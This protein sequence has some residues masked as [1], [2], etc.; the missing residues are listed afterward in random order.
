M[1]KYFYSISSNWINL[2]VAIAIAFIVSPI[3][4]NSL[5]KDVYGI[6]I[7][8]VSMTSY[9]TLL[10][11][12]VNSAIVKY[13]S[14]FIARNDHKNVNRIFSTSL[15]LFFL[16]AMIT[17]VISIF[18]ALNFHSF[19]E[20][21]IFSK[22]YVA[23]T[24]FIVGIDLTINLLFSVYLGTLKAFNK[25]VALNIINI[26][27]AITKN[28]IFVYLLLYQS[29]S[30]LTLSLVQLIFTLI[31]TFIHYFLIKSLPFRVRFSFNHIS[32]SSLKILYQY[33]IYSFLIAVSHKMIFYTDTIIIGAIIGVEEIAY[34]AIPLTLVQYIEQFVWAIIAVLIPIIS[35]KS[36]FDDL[37]STK[38]IYK[39]GTKYIFLLFSPVLVVLFSVGDQFIGMWMG[40]DFRIPS[41][42]ILVIFLCGYT[43]LLGQLVAHGILKGIGKHKWLAI[44]LLFE[45]TLNLCISLLLAPV[46]GIYGV[47][48]GTAIPMVVM[49]LLIIPYIT[50]YQLKINVYKYMLNSFAMPLLILIL[51]TSL[52]IMLNVELESYWQLILYSSIVVLIY[53]P[54]FYFSLENSEKLKADSY[55]SLYFGSRR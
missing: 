45:A 42:K 11:L 41:G 2:L 17:L 35:A 38:K 30:I 28:S 36:A 21:T 37:S 53:L 14:E 13:I 16:L 46:Y 23:L 6:W 44:T 24:F 4:V 48:I 51:I 55:L 50:S 47:A 26:V 40:D 29:S 27:I 33:S 5:G 19:F 39:L 20:I 25:F 7:L 15:F 12:G 54:I 8:I 3:L 10:D 52:L 18:L 34:Y 9:F 32:K 22:N 31:K 49:N 1:K 43:F